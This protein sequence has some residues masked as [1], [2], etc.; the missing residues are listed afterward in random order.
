MAALAAAQSMDR[1]AQLSVYVHVG[2]GVVVRRSSFKRGQRNKKARLGNQAH[3][4]AA[5][6]QNEEQNL[7]PALGGER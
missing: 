7:L 5:L 6:S 2:C 3:R 4:G 1:R